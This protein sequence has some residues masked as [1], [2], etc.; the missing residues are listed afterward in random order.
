MENRLTFIEKA[1]TRK[2]K[3]RGIYQCSCGKIKEIDNTL[4]KNNIVKSCG[5]LQKE[6]ASNSSKTHG[7]SKTPEYYIW[8]AMI[9]RITNSNNKQYFNYGG[10]GLT[11]S[12][13]WNDFTVFIKDMGKR[14]APKYSIERI[15]NSLG[16]CKENCKWA[17]IIEQS[18]NRRNNR[19]LTLNGKS[20]NLS[21]WAI[22]LSIDQTVLRR[23]LALGWN[24]IEMLT[25][26]LLK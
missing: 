1:P 20:Q 12:E 25:T 21:Q 15:D 23:R 11:I 22:E 3:S 5:C 2:E 8:K 6:R 24:D 16:Y 10:R 14:P 26:K 19:I 17:T 7:L 4:V 9:Q 13:K 18:N